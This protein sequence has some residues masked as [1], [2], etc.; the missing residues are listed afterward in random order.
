ML[1]ELKE[2]V[3]RENRRLSETGLAAFTWGNVS[4][5]DRARGLVV[6]KPSG[7]S[8][9]RMT[10]GDMAVVTLEGKPVEG[11]LRPSSD[12]PTH[13]AL[14]RSFSGIGA[15]VHT[16]SKWATI[17][18]QAGRDIPPY[19]TTHGDYFY[20]EIPCT[21]AMTEAEIEGAYERNTGEVIVERLRGVEPLAVPGVLVRSHGPFTWGA[22]CAAAVDNAPYLELIAEMAYGTETLGAA[23]CVAPM[24]RILLDRH[25][26]R[27]H[28]SGAY[29]GQ[30]GG[31]C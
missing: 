5:V 28:G 31:P 25:Y 4:G 20:G 19:G 16:H 3:C 30:G 18:A 12:L 27:K 23:E 10:P 8:Y 2:T 21:R 29:Y 7:V 24:D 14:Y 13:L 6:I 22:D 17:W 11:R 15:V 1:E 26:L 9:A